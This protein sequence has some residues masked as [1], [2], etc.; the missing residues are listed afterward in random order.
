MLNI[1]EKK[2]SPGQTR[3]DSGNKTTKHPYNFQHFLIS[4]NKIYKKEI[5]LPWENE[6]ERERERITVI[7]TVCAS[8]FYHLSLSPPPPPLLV[9]NTF[10]LT[11]IYFL[12]RKI[13]GPPLLEKE[14]KNPPPPG[15]AFPSVLFSTS[16]QTTHL[17]R[18]SWPH[19]QIKLLITE[20]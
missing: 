12:N 18:P 9:E 2:L 17:G 16:A 7:F 8:T 5:L 15:L 20:Q 6:R 14:K 19:K 4:P 13:V 10:S 11:L 3:L 1:P